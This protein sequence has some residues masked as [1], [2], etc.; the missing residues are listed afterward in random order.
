MTFSYSTHRKYYSPI[1][2]GFFLGFFQV[3][4]GKKSSI[5][6][7]EC[8]KLLDLQETRSVIY[9]CLGSISRVELAQLI[10]LA[11]ALESSN[12]PFIWEVRAGH[13]TNKIE[14]WIEKQWYGNGVSVEDQEVEHLRGE[15]KSIMAAKSDELKKAIEVVMDEGKEGEDIRKR[16]KELGK[17]A[18]KAE[19][20]GDHRI[21][22]CLD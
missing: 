1:L 20:N 3:Q 16:A 22:I 6:K 7:H 8:L 15:N 12:K 4:R 17:M 18:R 9:A 2:F 21:G 14:E 10:E 11:L 5:N 13:N 19:E